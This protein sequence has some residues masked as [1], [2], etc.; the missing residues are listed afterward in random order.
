VNV[1]LVAA[2]LAG[3]QILN[4]GTA[5][6]DVIGPRAAGLIGLVVGAAQAGLAAYRSGES[7]SAEPSSH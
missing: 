6:A 1:R 4:A 3:A 7:K 5:L 2:I